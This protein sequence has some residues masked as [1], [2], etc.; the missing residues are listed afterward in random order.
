T[1]ARGALSTGPLPRPSS[2]TLRP[3]ARAANHDTTPTASAAGTTMRTPKAAKLNPVAGKTRRFVRFDTG[4]G[5]DDAFA[6]ST[7][8]SR[9][10]PRA[11]RRPATALT[12]TGVNS[13]TVASRLNAAVIPAAS[14]ATTTTASRPLRA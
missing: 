14:S 12:T 5:N 4:S 9:A 7:V 1:G 2:G 8:A 11:S 13:T 6:I 10:G 3:T